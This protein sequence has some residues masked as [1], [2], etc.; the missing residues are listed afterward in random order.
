MREAPKID[1]RTAPDIARQVRELLHAYTGTRFDSEK[2]SSAALIDIFA[3][4]SELI[5][6]RLNRVPE[7]NFLAFLDLL[8]A[9]LVPPQPARAPLTFTLSEGSTVDA[10]VPAGTQVAAAPAEGETT[11]VVFE[12]ESELIVTAARLSSI[13][14]RDPEFDRSADWSLLTSQV[15][16]DGVAIFKLDDEK[17]KTEHVLYIAHD[18]LFSDPGLSQVTP[19][20]EIKPAGNT[21]LIKIMWETWD[22]KGW[23]SFAS[24]GSTTVGDMNLIPPSSKSRTVNGLEKIWLR[25]EL[26]PPFPP[27]LE[28]TTVMIKA[29][30]KRSG[31]QVEQAVANDTPLDVVKGFFPFGERPKTGD[32]LYLAHK[33]AFSESGATITLHFKLANS[34]TGANGLA[35]SYEFW[36]G[37]QWSG[38]TT[39]K[40]TT[41]SLTTSGDVIFTIPAPP[42][43][44]TINGVE[45]FWI[46]VRIAA[47]NYGEEAHFQLKT[48]GK[49]A[50]GFE[51]DGT[52]KG[53]IL[54]PATYAPP[55]VSSLTVD[56]TVNK[57]AQPPEVVSTYNDF[58][59]EDQTSVAS[60]Q[61]FQSMP[62]AYPALYLGFE[63]PAVRETFPQRKISIY[64]DLYE[65]Q[66]NDPPA[67]LVISKEAAADGQPQV[68]W[69][70]WTPTGWAKLLVRDG[71]E[72]LT[73]PG[74]IEFLGPAD[75]AL[76]KEFGRTQYWIR[77]VWKAGAY[78]YAPRLRRLLPNTIMAAQTVTTQ[79]E[80]L[81]S[82]D[83]SRNQKFQT[84]QAPLL[85]GQLLEVRESLAVT[86]TNSSN[87]TW[88]SWTEVADFYGSGARDRHYIIDH[89]TGEVS[90]GDGKRGMI[91]PM[92]SGNIRM[93]Q[94][95]TS[96]GAAGN[97][98]DG[99]ITQLKTT[100]PYVESVT[101]QLAADGGANAETPD[102]LK[103]R[104]PRTVRHRDRAVTIQDYEDLTMLA[105]GEVG[106]VRCVPL[107]DLE[108]NSLAMKDEEK[109]PGTVSLIIVPRSKDASPT[110]SIELI[111][112]VRAYMDARRSPTAKLVIVGPA[113]VEISV[114]V[115]VA[116]R[117]M[118]GASEVELAVAR[119]L[120][121]FL[122][123][124]TGGWDGKGWYFGTQPHTSAL[125]SLI[126][127]VAGVGHV[128]SLTVTPEVGGELTIK[129]VLQTDRFLI[130]SG[131]HTITLS[132][133]GGVS[134]I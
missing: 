46:R 1:R 75:F 128:R 68:D 78:Q 112:R 66:F 30:L 116:L 126:E 131:T 89:L 105:S 122:H 102:S 99:A 103:E 74:L 17:F 7:K 32:A 25:G 5:I 81:G 35:L 104:T 64:A 38:L 101:N 106:R 28:F 41:N 45:S 88:V 98:P 14:V 50:D 114:E 9:S 115:E 57:P 90:F 34:P 85:E 63:L 93:P 8:G 79:N 47:G 58:D 95:R 87:E 120:T 51:I 108:K 124:L 23:V 59:Y 83:G 4:Y 80:V 18:E 10:V 130:Y 117:S 42:V 48:P 15:S 40:D 96:G 91:P 55:F 37:H 71:T 76:Q 22:G 16:P 127:A 56:Y 65:Y 67:P 97:K 123:P 84:T 77:A 2:G 26:V 21:Q 73:Q 36:D 61:P 107:F 94:Y 11:P 86:E 6:E 125:Y 110:P 133:E 44:T 129:D 19:A 111:D 52:T 20:F 118:E 62:D 29:T 39:T 27:S 3:R 13:F 119:A 113:Y 54:I 49:P 134:S 43:L 12:T 33:E 24:S 109:E 70:Y 72:N 60:F 92:G 53:Y 121:S 31:Q 132:L 69:E 82:S 100:V